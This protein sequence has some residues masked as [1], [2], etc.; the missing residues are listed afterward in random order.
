MYFLLMVFLTFSKQ[1]DAEF[2][3][4]RFAKQVGSR[5]IIAQSPISDFSSN[6]ARFG[7]NTDF[8]R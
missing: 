3:R 5:P 1:N 2:G 8:F 7:S 4:R 6:F